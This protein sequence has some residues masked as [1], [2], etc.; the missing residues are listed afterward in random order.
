M[1]KKLNSESAWLESLQN[2]ISSFHGRDQVM[3]GL[4]GV[5]KV[6]RTAWPMISKVASATEPRVWVDILAGLIVRNE[7]SA[8]Q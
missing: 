4:S 5:K 6:E 8:E 7:K 3:V 1:V 2:Q